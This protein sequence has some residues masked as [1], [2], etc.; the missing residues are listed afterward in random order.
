MD[1]R[2]SDFVA[3]G[4]WWV[5]AQVPV[6][7]GA[8]LL[9]WYTGAGSVDLT[10]P[11]PLTGVAIV[12]AGLLFVV[13]GIAALGRDLTPYPRPLGHARLRREG[14]Y[15]IVRHPIYAGLVMASFG[16]ALAWKSPAGMVFTVFVLLFFDRKSAREETF[17]RTRY[18]DYR[19]YAGRV[20]KFIPWIY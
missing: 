10:A 17:L 18:S 20:R 2:F 12:V 11:M 13:A 9:P 3:R 6:L 4:G 15:A 5:I 19:D 14:V 7:A 16:W 8:L 1:Q